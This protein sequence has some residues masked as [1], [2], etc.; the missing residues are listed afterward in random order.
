[1]HA[2]ISKSLPKSTSDSDSRPS[3]QEATAR[4]SS[5]SSKA[6][7]AKRSQPEEPATKGKRSRPAEVDAGTAPAATGKPAREKRSRIASDEA[8][9]KPTARTVAADTN[10]TEKKKKIS[11]RK[12]AI[13]LQEE[14]DRFKQANVPSTEDIAKGMKKLWWETQKLPEDAEADLLSVRAIRTMHTELPSLAKQSLAKHARLPTPDETKWF[15]TAQVDFQDVFRYSRSI[16]EKRRRQL[17]EAE[18]D[19]A[20]AESAMKSLVDVAESRGRLPDGERLC[21][22]AVVAMQQYQVELAAKASVTLTHLEQ[23]PQPRVP[24]PANTCPDHLT[25]ASI[26]CSGCP[27]IICPSCYPPRS[28]PSNPHLYKWDCP[29]CNRPD[30]GVKQIFVRAAQQPEAM[31]VAPASTTTTTTSAATTTTVPS[32]PLP[33]VPDHLQEGDYSGLML[34]N[35]PDQEQLDMFF[36]QQPGLEYEQ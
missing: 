33:P 31:D 22:E 24:V 36:G 35:D 27:A 23:Q 8:S 5:R 34:A 29:K 17:E 19:H 14:L 30:I 4:T 10:G 11:V 18:K 28:D 32:T 16:V 13:S 12:A 20:L 7:V 25:E 6:H 3:S 15:A 2:A 21:N 1:M 26:K 9:T